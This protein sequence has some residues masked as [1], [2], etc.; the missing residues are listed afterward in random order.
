MPHTPPPTAR[1][2]FRRWSAEDVARA[3]SLWRDPQVMRFL[4]GPYSHEEV[5][6]RLARETANDA[7]HGIQYWPLFTRDGGAFAG[8]CGLKPVAGDGLEIGFHFLP[9]FWGAGYASEAAR[10]AIAYAFDQLG[11]PALFAGHHPANA[12]SRHL[13]TRLGFTCI[14]THFFARTGLDHPWYELRR[15]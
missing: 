13:L 3:A 8:C 6:E 12:A 10:A 11:T 4:G 7:A 15:P 14:G 9:P 5:V 1:L 2:A